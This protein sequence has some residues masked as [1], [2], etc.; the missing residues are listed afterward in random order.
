MEVDW[1]VYL[2]I[3]NPLYQALLFLSLTP[4]IIFVFQPKSA[5]KAWLIAVYTFALFLK[6]M[7]DYCGLMI[8]PGAS[9][10]IL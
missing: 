7:Q 6:S 8:A 10:F 3:Q 1:N 2:F 5:D 9:S 4:I